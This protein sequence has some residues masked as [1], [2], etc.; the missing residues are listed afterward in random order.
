MARAATIVTAKAS[1][2]FD[3]GAAVCVKHRFPHL[4]CVGLFIALRTPAVM[5]HSIIRC[6]QAALDGTL[7]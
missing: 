2:L 5:S 4:I 1:A 7:F 6:R 3:F